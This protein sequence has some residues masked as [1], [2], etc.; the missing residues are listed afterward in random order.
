MVRISGQ[1]KQYRAVLQDMIN[2][3]RFYFTVIKWWDH[4]CIDTGESKMEFAPLPLEKQIK[5]CES[6][7]AKLAVRIVSSGGSPFA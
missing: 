4:G 3:K 2:L 5:R 1:S 6:E 7:L